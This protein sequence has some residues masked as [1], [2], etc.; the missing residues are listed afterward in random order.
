M[1]LNK[2]RAH[3]CGGNSEGKFRKQVETI[4]S[5]LEHVETR[6]VLVPANRIRHLK[7]MR[8]IVEVA[9]KISKLLLTFIEG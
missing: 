8:I 2:L 7:K 6:F 3:N 9:C 5:E 1:H 4:R